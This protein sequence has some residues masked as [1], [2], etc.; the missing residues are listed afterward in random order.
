MG[1]YSKIRYASYELFH[2]LG[3]EI[4]NLDIVYFLCY[5]LDRILKLFK[6]I[7]I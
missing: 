2:Y 7:K 3:R 4:H 6:T 5:I 1:G